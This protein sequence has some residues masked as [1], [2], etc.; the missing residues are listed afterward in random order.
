M[1]RLHGQMDGIEC[2][3][4]YD[5]YWC[6]LVFLSFSLLY[7]LFI[8]ILFQRCFSPLTSFRM[9]NLANS[10]HQDTSER[11]FFECRF[12]F[13]YI[14][15]LS[16]LSEHM[17]WESQAI[18]YKPRIR[19]CREVERWWHFCFVAVFGFLFYILYK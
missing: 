10:G 13:F 7:Y 3:C 14:Y 6:R 1:W 17:K 2:V 4:V 15:T 12:I 9:V 16:S 11:S 5:V 8:F 18:Q 19:T